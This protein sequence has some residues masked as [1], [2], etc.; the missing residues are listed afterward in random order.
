[1][2]S[3][4]AARS[5]KNTAPVFAVALLLSFALPDIALDT[6][7]ADIVVRLTDT[8]TFTGF[9]IL[10]V[11]VIGVISSRRG[12]STKRRAVE[13]GMSSLAILFVVL[14]VTLFNEHV[15][16]PAL[17]VARPNIERL[18]DSGSLGAD[19]PDADAFYALGDKGDRREAL[20]ALLPSIDTPSLSNAV[21]SHWAHETGYSFPSGHSIAA[22]TLAT[23]VIGVGYSWL[24]GWRRRL[25]LTI[26]PIWAI[27]VAYSRVL[28]GVHR[29]IDVI[30]GALIGVACGLLILTIVRTTV[31]RFSPD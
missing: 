20:A 4:T 16:K 13:I 26:G 11:I 6:W 17:A 10:A 5:V 28:L 21:R 15:L 29:P 8:A 14:G 18:A 27:G 3:R 7:F 9:T 30:A 1:M 23:F 25:A 24:T 19:N 12:V 2:T 22:A 31:V